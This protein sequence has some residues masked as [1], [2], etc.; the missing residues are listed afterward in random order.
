MCASRCDW[1]GNPKRRHWPGIVHIFWLLAQELLGPCD[2]NWYPLIRAALA[3]FASGIILAEH[4]LIGLLSERIIFVIV[5][6]C[7]CAVK[8]LWYTLHP[9]PRFL[10]LLLH[11]ADHLFV[12]VLLISTCTLDCMHLVLERL[13][14]ISNILYR[15]PH[16]FVVLPQFV[17][18]LCVLLLLM[19]TCTP[20]C[21]HLVLEA[22]PSILFV[23]HVINHCAMHLIVCL[24][25]MFLPKSLLKRGVASV[26]HC[27]IQAITLLNPPC[28]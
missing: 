27:C 19:G 16:F 2:I 17:D 8:I 12:L 13:K 22:L 5:P 11:F 24:L 14:L 1:I 26:Y 20:D 23:R 10:I 15:L 28:D 9:L 6:D 7:G 4:P 25:R 21:I 18:H 3:R